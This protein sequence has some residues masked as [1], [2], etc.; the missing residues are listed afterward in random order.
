MLQVE[1]ERPRRQSLRV[2]MLRGVAAMRRYTIHKRNGGPCAGR[3]P[4][5][6]KRAQKRA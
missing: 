2:I 3:S 1:G 4:S 5:E 6:F